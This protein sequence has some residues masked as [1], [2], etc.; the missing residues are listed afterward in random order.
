LPTRAPRRS[1]REAYPRRVREVELA[2][3][4]GSEGKESLA[5]RGGVRD[6]P[7]DVDRLA[8]W[9]ERLQPL[10]TFLEKD[11]RAMKVPAAP[12]VEADADL[13]DPVIQVAHGRC[14]VAPQQLESL[15]LLEELARVELLD[16]AEERFGR[17]F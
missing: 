12:V 8:R 2:H 7:G 11:G 4:L 9:L 3:T 1:P 10:D 13:Q 6:E 15:V 5:R 14:G 17:R 16:A